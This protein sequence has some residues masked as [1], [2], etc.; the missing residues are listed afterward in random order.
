[1]SPHYIV[2]CR[3]SSSDLKWIVFLQMLVAL[4]RAGAVVMYDNLN[5]RQATSHRVQSDHLLHGHTLPIFL[6]TDQL[7]HQPRS[8]EI[9]PMSQQAAA[10]NS[11]CIA[12]WHSTHAAASC[13]RCGNL[14]G[15]DQDCWLAWWTGL[16]HGVEARLCRELDV[17]GHCQIVLPRWSQV[18]STL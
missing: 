3:I 6:A 15:L 4:K 7:H 10:T 17:L 18:P 8:A 1:M 14:P 13:P 2:K 9:Q 11:S 12:D 16:P 5:V